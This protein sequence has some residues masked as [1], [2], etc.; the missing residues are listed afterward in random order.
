VRAQVRA[1]IVHFVE[2]RAL[3]QPAGPERVE[4]CWSCWCI[5]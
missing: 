2:N 3:P 1:P 5:R 4:Q